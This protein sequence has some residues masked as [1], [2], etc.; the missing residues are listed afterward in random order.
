MTHALG[1]PELARVIFARRN[2]Q[3]PTTLYVGRDDY[4]TVTE[5]HSELAQD[6]PLVLV[7]LLT[8][9]GVVQHMTYRTPAFPASSGFSKT[10][11]P[12][13]EGQLLGVEVRAA[14]GGAKRGDLYAIVE[15]T[16]SLGPIDQEHAILC[17]DYVTLYQPVGWPQGMVRSAEEGPGHERTF[18]QPAPFAGQPIQLSIPS[19]LRWRIK[20]IR[21]SL[22]TTAVAGNR[23]VSLAVIALGGQQVTI[24]LSTVEHPPSGTRAYHFS[25]RATSNVQGL[26]ATELLPIPLNVWWNANATLQVRVSGAGGD[27]FSASDW[28]VEEAIS[29]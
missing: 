13:R 27:Q 16:H 24:A 9:L 1:N 4:L 25:D 21:A 11:F 10:R 22:T 23:L 26:I 14:A 29:A 6:P 28:F 15:L 3:P 17:A 19:L 7:R 5:I 12:L 20:G 18:T 2:V 8:P